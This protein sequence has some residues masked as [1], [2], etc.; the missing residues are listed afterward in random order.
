[1]HQE[2]WKMGAGGHRFTSG[3]M[4][5]RPECES[6]KSYPRARAVGKCKPAAEIQGPDCRLRPRGIFP[7]EIAEPAEGG[8]DFRKGM[9]LGVNACRVGWDAASNRPLNPTTDMSS[10]LIKNLPEALHDRLRQR[11]EKH[12]RS[13]NGEV[14]AILESE[15]AGPGT[16]ALPPA[17]KGLRAVDG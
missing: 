16:A 11:A 7:V 12:H 8:F 14:L 5:R 4:V 2:G 13:M 17:V 10:L 6:I 15:L 3:R 1:F 9:V